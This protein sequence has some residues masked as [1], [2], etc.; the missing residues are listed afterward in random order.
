L[1]WNS[2]LP[3]AYWLCS[4]IQGTV[5]IDHFKKFFDVSTGPGTIL[6]IQYVF[7]KLLE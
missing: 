5:F 2:L 6:N 1:Q 3:I 4:V 7:T